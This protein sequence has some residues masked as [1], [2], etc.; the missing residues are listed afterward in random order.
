[1][2]GQRSRSNA[3]QTDSGHA[4]AATHRAMWAM[5]NYDRFARAT[6]W[7][8]G[9]V[10]VRACGI[11]SGQRVLDVAAGTG[12]VAIRAAFEGASVVASDLTPEHFIAGRRAAAKAGPTLEWSE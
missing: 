10:L 6:V 12:N 5:G 4:T 11:A 2:P 7:E 1:M 9:P 8:L 3:P